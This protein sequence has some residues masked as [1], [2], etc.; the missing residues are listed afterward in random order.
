[1]NTMFPSYKGKKCGSFGHM[2]IIS[3]NGNKIITT[4][5]GGMLFTKTKEEREH[6]FKIATQ[7]REAARHYQHEEIGYNYRMSNICAGI[8]RGQF[9]VL[10]T[11]IAQKREI[12]NIYK[13]ELKDVPVK[14]ME[15][16]DETF[17]THWLSTLVVESDKVSTTD[18]IVAL[19]KENIESRPVWKPMHLQPVYKNCEFFSHLEEGSYSEYLFTQG[20]CLPSDTKMTKEEQLKVIDVI[21]SCF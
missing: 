15:E 10:D 20:I 3:F 21:K 7:A 13:E 11:R 8:G 14:M 19:E 18:I 4:S 5:G 2:N 17:C 12:Y 6:T 16:L 1:M 9:E